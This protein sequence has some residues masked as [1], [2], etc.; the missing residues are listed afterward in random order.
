MLVT[1]LRRYLPTLTLVVAACGADAIVSAPADGKSRTIFAS[2]GQEVQ[3]TLGNVGPA[4]YESPPQIS[5][6]AVA[7]IGVEVIPPFNPGG[8]TQQFRFHAAQP[9]DAVIHFRRV[10]GTDVVSVVDDTIR[11]R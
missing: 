11:V 8:P 1:Q 9:G 7:F 6:G 2:V 3:I 4:M 10:L 5:S